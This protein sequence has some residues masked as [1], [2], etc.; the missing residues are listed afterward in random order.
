MSKNIY[1]MITD[2]FIEELEQGIIP[3]QKPWG[4]TTKNGAFN[5]VSKRPY[6]LLNQ[7]LLP[8]QGSWA[9]FK[10]WSDLGGKIKKGEKSSLVVFWKVLPIEE[11]KEDGTKEVKQVPYLRYY[12]VFHE[13]QVENVEPL[14][15]EEF[16]ELEPIEEAEK[17]LRDYWNRENITVN[18]TL[19]DKAFYSP[20]TDRITLP[21]FEQFINAN[22]YYSTAYHESIHS[23]MK[24]NRCNREAERKGKDV[25]FGSSDYSF[26]ECVAEIGSATILNILGI[27]TPK[28][29][30][31]STAYLQSWLRVLKNDNRFIISASSKAEKAVNYIMNIEVEG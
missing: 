30:K 19:G 31:N 16:T 29:F 6:S 21:M 20:L 18:H 9:T 1:Q 14:T 12:N 27:E 25:S 23:T 8:K 22:E 24:A 10:Q 13:S 15:L 3:W 2:R 28:T 7:M 11:V 26:E 17:V 4:G 5:R